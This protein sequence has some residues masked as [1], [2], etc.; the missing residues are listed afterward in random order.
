MDYS[1]AAVD[2]IRL[3]VGHCHAGA[4][5]QL[6]RFSKGELLTL[7][8]LVS[9]NETVFPSELSAAGD[10]SSARIAAI[11]NSLEAKGLVL[12]EMDSGDRRKIL[13][14]ITREG[15]ARVMAQRREIHELITGILYELGEKDTENFIRI[16]RRVLEISNKYRKGTEHERRE[17]D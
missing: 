5:E 17:G 6:D 15:R 4:F 2:L 7:N 10:F 1:A 13:V 3:M 12:R 11:L 14:S 8:Y 9:R 16:L